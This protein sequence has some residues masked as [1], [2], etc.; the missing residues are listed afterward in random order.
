MQGDGHR[1]AALEE[2]KD[3]LRRLRAARRI[4]MTALPGRAG[5]GRTTVSQALNGPKV[6]SVD[7]ISALCIALGANPRPLLELRRASLPPAKAA[8]DPVTRFEN[9]YREYVAH[10]FGKLSVIGLDLARP[11]RSHW[12]LDAAYLSLELAGGTFDG[13]PAMARAARAEQAL[14]GY[15]R[16]LV[17][18]LAGSGKTTLLHWLA[19]GAARGDLPDELDHLRGC[20]P[21]VLRLR[22]LVRA[23]TLPAPEGYLAAVNCP[24]AAAQP[25]GW[26][27]GVLA[28]GRGLVLVDGVDEVP[29]HQRARTSGWLRDLLAAYPDSHFLV[30]T[31]PSAVPEGWLADSH[32]T[33]LTVQPMAPRDVSVFLT[34][35]HS[36]AAAD[37][38]D[39]ERAY[40]AELEEKLKDAVRSQRGLAQMTTTPLLCAL[41]CALHR[42]RH[43][44]LPHGRMDL[45]A[46]AL[47]MLLNRR[48]RERDIRAVENL[49]IGERQTVRLLQRLAYWMVQNGQAEMDR[50]DALHLIDE[51]LPAMPDV[52]RQ[53]NAEEVLRHLVAR[54][55]LLRALDDTTI[56]FVHRTFQDYL[57]AKAA[58]DSRHFGVL[59][60]HAHDTRW[61]DVIRMA[62]AHASPE[63][64]ANL[65]RRLIARGD[66]N[67]ASV[68][69]RNR[70]YVL[71]TACLAYAPELAPD[72]RR[73][74]ET[75]TE[76]LIP[77]RSVAEA[78]VLA[79]AGPVIL[80]LLPG[81]EGLS[82]DEA[83]AVV[84]TAL[85]VGG[86]AA[87]AFLKRFRECTQEVALVALAHGWQDFDRGEYA[88]EV[89]AHVR[90]LPVLMV[91]SAEEARELPHVRVP[92]ELWIHGNHP[93]PAP[94]LS[95]FHPGNLVRLHLEQNNLLWHL[96]FLRGCDRLTT[97]RIERCPSLVDITA[98]DEAPV[99]SLAI[100]R[101]ER[102]DLRGLVG[103][104]ALKRLELGLPGLTHT[105]RDLAALP[106]NAE[107]EELTLRAA[108]ADVSLVGVRR[109]TGLS[110]LALAERRLTEEEA[111]ELSALPRLGSLALDA[112]TCRSLMTC[113]SRIDRVRDLTL[114][115]QRE[116]DLS[117]VPEV[118]PGLRHV[119]ILLTRPQAVDLT[120]FRPIPDLSITIRGTPTTVHG[121]EHFP[122][123]AVT[124][125]PY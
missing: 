125:R 16:V 122:P 118:L 78:R 55:G 44:H 105:Y 45:Y 113:S 23:E 35:W 58:I 30:T 63:E 93:L 103:C 96:E 1:A 11:E 51:A 76:A 6:P 32:F 98:L 75:R 64:A 81:P 88:H 77:P 15:Q 3:T 90:R 28:A 42:D 19:V 101:C 92:T 33:E 102:I 5:L 53:G 4:P 94:V 116:T 117:R 87:L 110:R 13:R 52:A 36:A 61:E 24:L 48:D 31:R 121:A 50:S 70:L 41:V 62:V 29:Q 21:F 49:E 39:E 60:G 82:E 120:P 80:D 7:T 84:V 14:A 109:W 37:A 119:T 104:T 73:E 86:D 91:E 114:R 97:V 9:R 2:L 47:A 66:R 100:L 8:E 56:D 83:H 112:E 72:A 111:G 124:R 68:D 107:L 123:E 74:V 10:R 12:P 17:R 54:S 79:N 26:A 38:G 43:G 69:V 22:T 85:Q 71:A 67:T 27:D 89:L 18:G 59:A 34:R 108:C 65:L 115:T 106:L 57:A 20:V 46:A 40:L 95:P 25:P 99:E